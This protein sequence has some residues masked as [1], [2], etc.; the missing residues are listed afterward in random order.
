MY[1]IMYSSGDKILYFDANSKF[2][3]LV[4]NGGTEW[5]T[6][7][8]ALNYL[9]SLKRSKPATIKRW[10]LQRSDLSKLSIKEDGNTEIVK[11]NLRPGSTWFS[12]NRSG[13]DE[14]SNEE[15]IDNAS[16]FNVFA[17]LVNTF[18]DYHSLQEYLLK[19]EKIVQHE[20]TITIDILHKI[21]LHNDRILKDEA[22]DFINKIR[23]S[24]I[25]RRIAKDNCNLV[26]LLIKN[27]FGS[28]DQI[29]SEFNH[30]GNRNYTDRN[31]IN[32]SS[33]IND[34]VTTDPMN[35][36]SSKSN[37]SRF[38]GKV[39]IDPENGTEYPTLSAYCAAKN[40]DIKRV[41]YYVHKR[42]MNLLDATKASMALSNKLK[43]K[44]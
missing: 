26:S 9:K 25:R 35:V 34:K 17:P 7:S 24:R 22:M 40:V 33:T 8:S 43:E 14:L 30:M 4:N 15:I 36:S 12:I 31:P 23:E 1:K 6:R 41:S 11:E 3:P 27:G 19:Q 37:L 44:V 13:S 38:K 10:G 29:S 18:K 42:N 28:I 2:N 16:L 21:E 20:D 32:V 5:K 39:T